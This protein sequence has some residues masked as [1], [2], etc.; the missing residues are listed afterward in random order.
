MLCPGTYLL[1]AFA[2]AVLTKN[3]VVP[4]P[5]LPNVY[6]LS[7]AI[8]SGPEATMAITPIVPRLDNQLFPFKMFIFISLLRL[9]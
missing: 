4:G 3:G 5:K 6:R 1:T 8:A 7:A 2:K 9:Y